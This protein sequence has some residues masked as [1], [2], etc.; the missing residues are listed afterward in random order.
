MTK[1]PN[2]PIALGAGLI[3]AIVFASA[4][5]GPTFARL[6]ML[7]IVTLPIALAGYS[8]NAATAFL[9]AAAGTAVIA[10]L[11]TVGA[12]VAFATTLA[13]PAAFLVYLALLHR[14]PEPGSTE[15][16]PIGR[17]LV[18]T[19][20]MAATIVAVGFIVSGST[21]DKLNAAVSTAIESMMKSGFGGMPAGSP[22]SPTD[23]ARFTNMMV[24]L[25]PGVSAAFWMA[26]ILLCQ[27]AA[28]RVAIASGQLIRPSPDFAALQLPVGTPL[29]LGLAVAA[30]LFLDGMPKLMAMGYAGALYVVYALLGLAVLHY[31][32]R[33]YSWRGPALA[34]I[35]VLLIVFNSGASLLLAIL[36]LA[37]SFFSLRRPV[38]PNKPNS[39]A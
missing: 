38:E 7:A 13:L 27:W 19:S 9:A 36:G 39:N 31:V 1:P 17:I 5:T 16:Y 25:L 12:S 37:D 24:Q 3:S 11:T 14:D 8:Y 21:P 28:A 2:I 15:W 18:A 22:L 23:L 4:T 35:Y 10:F 20:I 32:T 26:C 34:V 29:L 30:S 6:V 33:P